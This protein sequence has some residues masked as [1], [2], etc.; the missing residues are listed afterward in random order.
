M[1]GVTGRRGESRRASVETPQDAGAATTDFGKGERTRRAILHVAIGR[2]A[3]RGFQ[4]TSVADIARAVG[5]SPAAAYRYFP[6]K[7][8]LFLAAVDADAEG[9]V[10]LARAALHAAPVVSDPAAHGDASL[11]ATLRNLGA[12]VVG[13]V[14]RHPLIARCLS[15]QEPVSIDAILDGE[16]LSVLRDEIA[17][18]LRIGQG[19]GVVRSDIDVSVIALGLESIVLSALAGL[20]M[21]DDP[22]A[23]DP[24]WAA[25]SAVM[26][27]AIRPST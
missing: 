20:V 9:L 2:F 10:S 16:Q 25:V 19:V 14:D 15:G 27:A 11:T 22:V 7:E 6:D 23:D 24:R 1:S 13:A 17:D 21:S 26:D 18:L 4:R 8:G 5:I 3:A 12:V